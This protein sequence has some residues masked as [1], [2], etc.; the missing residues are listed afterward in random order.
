MK[1]K[2]PEPTWERC[3]HPDCGVIINPLLLIAGFCMKH[4]EEW[5]QREKARRRARR[6]RQ[7]EARRG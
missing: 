3:A 7:R 4:E 1:L 5:R 2:R 6:E